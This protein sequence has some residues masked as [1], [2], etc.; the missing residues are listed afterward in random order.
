M[1]F[2]NACRLLSLLAFISPL[3]T[4]I[5]ASY[6]YY[7][8]P[9]RY[10]H[11][12]PIPWYIQSLYVRDN[13]DIMV[14]TVWPIASVWVLTDVLTDAPQATLIYKF[15]QVNATTAITETEPDVFAIIGANQTSLGVGIDGDQSIWE[16]DLRPG[17]GS[18]TEGFTIKEIIHLSEA[19]LCG[20]LVQ[21]PKD[22]SILLLA[23]T[24]KGVIWRVDTRA[25]TYELAAR[26]EH[27]DWLPWFITEFGISGVKI[28]DGYLYWTLS[29][30]ATIWR[31]AIS[32]DGFPLPGAKPEEVKWIRSVFLDNFAF[33]SRDNAT[34]FAA[35]NADNR[36]VAIDK[37]GEPTYVAGTPDE[38]ILLGPTTPAFGKVRGDTNTVYV[39][40]C[41]AILNPINGTT[42]EGG[43]I[44]AIDTTAFFEQ[45]LSEEPE[46]ELELR[47]EDGRS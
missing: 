45:Y 38:M 25:H 14:T 3:V 18:Y 5:L 20:S 1:R 12:W 21:L 24:H 23:D 2:F 15:D 46:P 10:I 30:A 39:V 26:E 36:L 7:P 17:N 11:Q 4:T 13:G 29:Y 28:Q 8:L 41:G 35:L 34:I 32:D 43:R 47:S 42:F 31:I 37:H 44:V 40:T 19:G 27:M 33:A 6:P 22:P 9:I 16:L